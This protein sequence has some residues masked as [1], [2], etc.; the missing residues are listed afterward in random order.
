MTWTGYSAPRSYLLP[1]KNSLSNPCSTYLRTPKPFRASTAPFLTSLALA[2]ASV[3]PI[4]HNH[5]ACE[6]V[7]KENSCWQWRMTAK[8]HEL[9]LRRHLSGRENRRLG[10]GFMV[11]YFSLISIV[12][13]VVLTVS[14]VVLPLVLPPL[15]PPPLM[16]LSI[17]VFLMI[18]LIFLALLPPEVPNVVASSVW[19]RALSTKK[20][21][22]IGEGFYVC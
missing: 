12:V 18:A 11:R 2:S 13:L 8:T 6:L 16:L 4:T 7:S 19:C 9:D 10:E 3:S 5:H 20:R 14:L 22:S 17:P 21:Y 15:P 1:Y